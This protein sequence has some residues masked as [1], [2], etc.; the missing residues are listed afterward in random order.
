MLM[1]KACVCVG[2][3]G[4][5]GLDV[6]IVYACDYIHPARETDKKKRQRE[7]F[8]RKRQGQRKRERERESVCV[9]V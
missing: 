8:E 1:M 6:W 2:P 9:C 4:I 5:V 7:R 3:H